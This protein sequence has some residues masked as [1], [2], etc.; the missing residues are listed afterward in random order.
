MVEV[1]F[2]YQ[3]LSSFTDLVLL[4][5]RTVIG[6]TMMYYG[7]RKFKDLKKN[8]ENFEKDMGIKPGWFWGTLTAIMEAGGSLLLIL[9]VFTWI[10]ATLFAGQM[11]VGTFF[12]IAKWNK[13]FTDWS[14]DLLI[15]V[16]SLVVLAFGGGAYT[17]L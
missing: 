12:K 6:V 10:W 3:P 17:L 13:P 9:G 5:V 11:I 4:L 8:A 16:L 2:S 1:F 7:R 15:L 14:Y